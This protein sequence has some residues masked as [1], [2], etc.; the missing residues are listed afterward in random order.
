MWFSPLIIILFLKFASNFFTSWL[1]LTLCFLCHISQGT[2]EYE[3]W[4]WENWPNMAE[5]LEGYP[6]LKVPSSLLLTQLPL[7]KPRLFSISSSPRQYPGEIH[8]TVAVVSYHPNG[9]H[10][11]WRTGH[12]ARGAAAPPPL[13]FSNAYFRAKKQ[14]MPKIFGQDTSTPPPPPPRTKLVP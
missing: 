3:E 4:K 5:V 6:S 9:E 10:E 14:A 11:H 2:E 1:Y 7:L 12:W 13:D 8:A